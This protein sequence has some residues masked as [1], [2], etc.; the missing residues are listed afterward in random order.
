VKGIRFKGKDIPSTN[1][2][3]TRLTEGISGKGKEQASGKASGPINREMRRLRLPEK[4]EIAQKGREEKPQ[5]EE[6]EA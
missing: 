1:R 4:S 3:G 2:R 6:G 5:K